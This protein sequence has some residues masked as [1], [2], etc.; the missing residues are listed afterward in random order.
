MYVYILHNS[1]HAED[2]ELS[3]VVLLHRNTLPEAS[4]PVLP[5]YYTYAGQT[6]TTPSFTVYGVTRPKID[7]RFN[8]SLGQGMSK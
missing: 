5:N 8:P 6:A 4:T 1:S 3:H 7:P 2:F